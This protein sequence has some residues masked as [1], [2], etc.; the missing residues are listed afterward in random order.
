[1]NYKIIYRCLPSTR[2]IKVLL[3]DSENTRKERGN[4]VRVEKKDA[5]RR[6]VDL[7]L[8]DLQKD[9]TYYVEIVAIDDRNTIIDRSFLIADT[10]R[11]DL[12]ADVNVISG[13]W[14]FERELSF[15]ALSN[16]GNVYTHFLAELVK[17]PQGGA[18]HE[19]FL[20][21]NGVK[22]KLSSIICYHD[23]APRLYSYSI[24][25][26]LDAPMR[27]IMEIYRHQLQT[28][29]GPA[30]GFFQDD[31]EIFVKSGFG[32]PS[33]DRMKFHLFE[34]IIKKVIKYN[35]S[36]KDVK[37]RIASELGQYL[38][39]MLALDR[40]TVKNGFPIEATDTAFM[41]LHKECVDPYKIFCTKNSDELEVMLGVG[42]CYIY[43]LELRRIS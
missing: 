10:S 21:G 4:I 5:A 16:D 33:P 6:R 18:T 2:D 27:N 32:F 7:A 23:P 31:L 40:G 25:F 42:D 34:A 8:S 20:I 19:C 37:G 28:A 41:A 38:S 13:M 24:K 26:P 29:D 9:K 3:A 22:T 15:N 35:R 11:K 14:A 1:M 17:T 30:R 39:I 43:P 36:M 12:E